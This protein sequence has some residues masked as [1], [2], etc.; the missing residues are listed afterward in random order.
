MSH[1]V[2]LLTLAA[3][4]A[5]APAFPLAAQSVSSA[6][7]GGQPETGP[8]PEDQ[9]YDENTIVVSGARV[10]GQVDAPQPPILELDAADIA[11]YGAGSIAELI[12]ALGSDVT[13]SRGRGSGGPVFLVGGVRIASFREMRSF[14]P[15]AI[16]K[17]EVFSEEVAQQ[18]GYSPNQRVVNFI[19]K[20]NFS[21][22]EIEVEYGQPFDGGYSTQEVEGTYVR[23]DG[24]S[25]LNLNLDWNNSSLLTEGERGVLQAES[26]TP[27]YASDPDPAD[28]RSLVADSA[29]LEATLNWAMSLGAGTSLSVNG[30]FEREDSLRLQGLDEVTLSDGTDT[31]LRAF[32]EGDP[33]T[34]DKR[35]ETYSG[36]ATLNFGLGDWEVTGTADA[37]LT[38]AR[39]VTGQAVDTSALE[40]AAIAG[41]LALDADLTGLFD[42]AGSETALTDTYSVNTLLTARGLPVYLP[43]GDVS[44]T[45]NTG[46]R[47]NGIDSEDTRNPGVKTNL[48]RGQLQAGVN[49]GVPLTSRDDDFLGAVG[50]ISLNLTAGVDELTDF[51]TL[52]NWSAGV[53]WGLTDSLTL[54]ATYINQEDAPSL[55]ELGSAE[56]ATPNV[57]FYDLSRDETVLVTT[58]SGGNPNLEKQTQ[59]DW[60]VGLQW[61][62]PVF[63]RSN[64]TVDY[65]R[66][67]SENV[68]GSFPTLTPAIEAA[69][70]DRVTRDPVS[71]QIVSINQRPVTFA[72]Q[73]VERIAVGLNFSGQIAAPEA[74]AG[75][76]DSAGAGGPAQMAGGPIG[77]AAGGG[78]PE[79]FAAM[80]AQFCAAE[81]ADMLALLNRALAAS[82][83]GEAMPA[84]PDGQPLAIP[85]QMLQRLAGAD[86]TVDPERFAQMRERMCSGDGPPNAAQAGGGRGPGGRGG[87]GGPGGPGFGRPGSDGGGRWFFN[88]N[89]QFDLAN[90]VL[91][92]PGVPVLDLLDGD[93][94]SGGGQSEHTVNLRSGVFYRG[95][96]LITFWNYAS[97][98]RLDG[99]G[100]PGSTDLY[101]SDL[102]TI[103]FRAFADL[104]AQEKLVAAVPFLENTRVGIGVDN[105]FDAR[106]Q[107]TDSNGSVP[108]RYQPLL[109]DPVGRSFEIEFRKLF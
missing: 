91:I 84:G 17:V 57:P 9:T 5:A 105:V 37:T 89:Y 79:R 67:H 56:I 65:I 24:P 40:D 46:Y 81:P 99:S 75:G 22:R 35:T 10:I 8:E 93:A 59:S 77:G 108:L 15:E 4:L 95:F 73:D 74:Q 33:L 97:A 106:Q 63:D 31:V 90:T 47:W 45:L 7:S 20:D 101:F 23:I 87:P 36:A 12:E 2:S 19:L 52:Y 76:G 69:F 82:A 58:I 49:V 14:P 1:Q 42:A 6:Q 43:A 18:Y 30:T 100:L 94:I 68:S 28:Y 48:N 26:S 64:L 51:G 55:S 96:G 109:V 34:V 11:A 61:E 16:E 80:R 88:V 92:A 13:S 29:S 62:I 72:E 107:V 39:S 60:K 85:P 44:V 102:L 53:T 21:S 86:G 25:R 38:H 104:G 50:D 71:G 78:D 27:T 98:T 3:A 103:N 54:N 83:A 66:N 32:N 41:T 70:P